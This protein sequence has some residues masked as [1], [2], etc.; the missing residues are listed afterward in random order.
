MSRFNGR[1]LVI[2]MLVAALVTA[3]VYFGHD[4]QVQRHSKKLL[5][6]AK[7]F[8]TQGQL[9]RS[10]AYLDRY[11]YFKPNESDVLIQFGTL[12]QK[13]DG[14]NAGRLS[15][16]DAFEKV[17]RN[18]RLSQD[19]EVDIRS[20]MA[21]ICLD[22]ERFA[23]ARDNADWVLKYRPTDSDMESLTGRCDEAEGRLKEA[24]DWF[25][26]AITHNPK[27]RETYLHLALMLR[28]KLDKAKHADDV[29]ERLVAANSQSAEAFL[30][31]SVYRKTFKLPGAED[32]STTALKLAPTNPVALL[33]AAN[34]AKEKRDWERAKRYLIEGLG[35]APRDRRFYQA[36]ADLGREENRFKDAETYL[37]QGIA[38]LP[39]DDDLKWEAAALQILRGDYA[40]A[41]KAISNLRD[42]G[43]RPELLDYLESHIFVAQKQ[44]PK[45][46]KNL[47]RVRPLLSSD[48]EAAFL[49]SVDA[50][51]IQCY[52]KM[53]VTAAD[54]LYAT[55]RR[56]V[57]DNPAGDRA[58]LGFAESLE[59]MGNFDRALTQYQQVASK[60]PE[61]KIEVARLMILKNL[62]LPASQRRWN[63]VTQ[64]LDAAAQAVPNSPRVPVLR[65][66]ALAAQDK[67]DDAR[68]LL[69]KARD[70]RPNEPLLW[71]ALVSILERRGSLDAV[72]PVLDAAV[73]KLGDS[74][75]L[76]L[77]RARYVSI[78]GGSQ[79]SVELAKLAEGL[80]KFT[81]DDQGQLLRGLAETYYRMGDNAGALKL[82]SQWA[83]QVPDDLNN[84]LVTFELALK[85]NDDKA[86]STT[87]AAIQS[88]E[89]REETDGSVGRHCQAMYLIWKA[90]RGDKSGLNEARD[91]LREVATRR[92]EWSRVSLAEAKINELNGDESGTIREY[93]RAIDLGE[94]DP[95]VVRKTIELLFKRN[96]YADANRVM[97]KL[98]DQTVVS[99]QLQRYAAEASLR[100][101]DY[102]HAVELAKR[103]VSSK[104]TNY[105]DYVWLGQILGVVGRTADAE[106]NL[107]RAIELAPSDPEP[108]VVLVQFL[109]NTG[110]KE[111]AETELREVESHLDSQKQL[112]AIALCH[113]LV[114]HYDQARDLYLTAAKAKPTDSLT[115]RDV[116]S[117]FVRRN[118]VREAKP[119]LQR[120]IDLPEKPKDDLDWANETLAVF[121]A[122][123]GDPQKLAKAM[124][125][126][127]SVPTSR[128]ASAK[129]EKDADTSVRLRSRAQVLAGQKEPR[130]RRE[131]IALLEGLVS[132]EQMPNDRFL[133]AQLYE[134]EGQWPKAE[135]AM[136][137]ALRTNK[138]SVY[139]AEYI[140]ALLRHGQA[141]QAAPWIAELESQEPNSQRTLRLRAL[142]L[143]AIGKVDQAIT[144][145][146]NVATQDPAQ[147]QAA[148]GLLEEMGENKAAEELLRD[149]V[150][151]VKAPEAVLVLAEFLGR[152]ERASEGLDLC[153]KVW[154]SNPSPNAAMA[155]INILAARE[156]DA[157]QIKRAEKWIE[158]ALNKE[159][160]NKIYILSFAKI[161]YLE[162][163]YQE[164]EA[165]YRRVLVQD[166]DDL[167]AL[168][169]ISWMLAH[170]AGR[171]NE[172]LELINR[173]IEYG[174][175]NPSLLDTRAV[176]YLAMNHGDQAI[177][178]LEAAITAD[179]TDPSKYFHL[180]Q[181]H[182]AVKN[183]KAA[184]DAIRNGQSHGLKQDMIDPTERP[185][186]EQVMAE[187]GQK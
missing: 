63:E 28:Q 166:K 62:N 69:E 99:G 185:V 164:S 34:F 12:I 102:E 112:L 60:R 111:K 49:K 72:A 132:R 43:Y 22:L 9:D 61:V 85:A 119:F 134:A 58:T 95:E 155:S 47:E 1:L 160:S 30:E 42:R 35:Y 15:A 76:R 159:P 54:Q 40:K 124:E 80:D 145:V 184:I 31:R 103:A 13:L 113:E 87:V 88:L 91:L 175:P 33:L 79:A 6:Q 122:V 168:N 24:A 177:A 130:L 53:G 89:K 148:A 114:K 75:D 36:L 120:I 84:R 10:L 106:A 17:L 147:A 55:Y 176:V 183:R 146:K 118:E 187:L 182:W 67:F 116:A 126:I 21:R 123:E 178:D 73:Q 19:V 138:G 5:D 46:A 104:S 144:M 139:V 97:T 180:A 161:R 154:A 18:G 133:L 25:E 86:M 11:L 2:L 64:A 125:M 32:D 105:R 41:S 44:W 117:Y 153:E 143:K 162:K 173:A 82:W 170:A 108:R 90:E 3:A 27:K 96:R 94:R 167:T 171:E 48:T 151:R 127:G 39:N 59:S 149:V 107:R 51:L 140:R 38:E 101:R 137:T 136:R 71:L 83:K 26:R 92:P 78:R 157:R 66:E 121:L 156:P 74:V 109:A 81:I 131:A 152:H 165:A 14:S 142:V 98:Q 93:T 158:T 29:M 174:G 110:Q 179:A 169:N 68:A 16:L 23:D 163:R 65:A 77:A 128:T 45:A 37:A 181:A 186:Y 100:N 172:A 50:M 135:E 129:T 115:L 141:D 7:R 20:R 52:E 57:A 56:I 4:Y 8:E 70:A 150:A